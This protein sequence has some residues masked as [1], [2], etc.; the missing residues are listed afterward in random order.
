M[1]EM[2]ND[3]A[4][5][6]DENIRNDKYI[7]YIMVNQKVRIEN[8]GNTLGMINNKKWLEMNNDKRK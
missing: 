3:W 7:I 4:M 5:I 8:R 1:R 2:K 6:N